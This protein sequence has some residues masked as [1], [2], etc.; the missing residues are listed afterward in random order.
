MTNKTRNYTH[1]TAAAALLGMSSTPLLGAGF[2]LAERSVSGL[3]RAFS[4]EAAIADDASVI[5]S[6]AAGMILLDDGA[7]SVGLQYIKPDVDVQG[8]HPNP[9]VGNISD[10]DI[11]EDALV[12][13]FYY[14][15]KIN[16]NLS[17]GFGMYSSFGLATEY[18]RAFS[19]VVGS[20]T[21]EIT[22]VTLNPSLAY[23]LNDQWTIGAG[24]DVL[25]AEGRLTNYLGGNK[26]FDLEGD[27]WSIGWNFGVLFEVSDRTRIGLQYRSSIDL[28]I[29]GTAEGILVGSTGA[30][31]RDA[32]LSI[33]LPDVAELSIYHELN[34]KWAIHSDVTW[35]GWS[36]FKT[37]A[38]KVH[39]GIDPLLAVQENWEDSYRYAIG[40]TYKHSEKVTFRC[41][42]AY[43]ETPVSDASRTLRIPDGD[44]IWASIGATI[45]LNDCYNLDLA[46]THLFAD[47]TRIGPNE[48]AFTGTAGGDVDLV[49][50]GISGTF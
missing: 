24:I 37:L 34:D 33:E 38:P 46:Y 4:G 29:E 15:R 26:F 50:I 45:K 35:T 17:A 31:K 32:S 30:Y 6:N 47:D 12:P 1:V 48:P 25:Y 11:A 41:G 19:S 3:G 22:T 40:A 27:D 28:Q 7:L 13:Y 39:A 5:A 8:V 10:T 23:R 18:S 16:D 36:K 2:Q 49:G 14:S 9:L 20:E 21:S 44:R 42:L 43:D